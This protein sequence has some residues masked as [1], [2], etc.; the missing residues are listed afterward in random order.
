MKMKAHL[1]IAGVTALAGLLTACSPTSDSS[2]R[3]DN[4]TVVAVQGEPIQPLASADPEPKGDPIQPLA[5]PEASP[6]ESPATASVTTGPAGAAPKPAPS[7]GEV[8]GKL[9][10]VAEAAVPALTNTLTAAEVIQADGRDYLSVGFD[11]LASFN[12]EMTDD[13]LEAKGDAREIT[14]KTNGQIPPKLRELNQKSVAVKGYMLPLKVEEGA[15]TEFLLMRDQSMC[16]FGTVPKINE[17]VSVKTIGKGVKPVM[18]EPV[19]IFGK[20]HVGEMREN[21]YLVG[22]YRMDGEKL[23]GPLDL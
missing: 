17:W 1:Q 10:V 5:G 21:G 8:G 19:T 3:T 6:A 2:A 18:D 23:A 13:L 9:E 11:Q 12:F 4:E 7:T 15:V 16:C 22:I 14:E 20:L